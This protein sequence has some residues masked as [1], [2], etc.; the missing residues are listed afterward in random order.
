MRTETGRGLAHRH[1]DIAQPLEFR[2]AF[3]VEAMD[4]QF[5]RPAHLGDGL[6]D[7]GED[8][9]LGGM[10]AAMAR[11]EF[12]ARDHVGAGALPGERPSARPG[13]NWPS[14]HRR[15]ACRMP[16]K[17]SRITRTCRRSVAAE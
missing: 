7:A 12:A 2:L 14:S 6:A 15:R 3:E 16:A 1:G 5:E 4:A 10:P 13:W 11:F 8:D 17:A 9:P